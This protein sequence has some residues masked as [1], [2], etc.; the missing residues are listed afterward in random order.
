[1]QWLP[2][3]NHSNV[4][5]LTDVRCDASRHFRTK[6]KEYL[7]AKIDELQNNGKI[8]IS[9]LHKGISDLKKGYQ[10]RANKVKDEKGDLVTDSHRIVARWRNHFS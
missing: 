2:D 8:K 10:H 9:D 6:K 3:L 5:N 1:M 7:K 4:D